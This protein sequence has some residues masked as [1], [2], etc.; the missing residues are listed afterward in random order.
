MTVVPSPGHPA[1][2][3]YYAARMLQAMFPA[4]L[5]VEIGRAPV[6]V[7]SFLPLPTLRHTRIVVPAGHPVAAA[8]AVRR[9]LTGRRLRT[10]ASRLLLTTALAS[11]FV[12]LLHRHPLVVRGDA[13]ADG[14]PRLLAGFLGQPALMSFAVGPAR[15]NRKPVLQLT[16]QHGRVLAFAKVGHDDL[17]RSLVRREADA[18][19]RLR[20]SPLRG[21]RAPRVLTVVEWNDLLVLVLEPLPI[22]A[23]SDEGARG[24]QRLVEAVREISGLSSWHGPWSASPLRRSLD[25]QLRECGE[26]ASVLRSELAALD[27]ADPELRLGS[28]H[29]DLNPGNV[30]LGADTV[31]VWD[32]ERFADQ[33]PVGFDLLHHDLHRQIT[34]Q[35]LSPRTAAEALIRNAPDTLLPLGAQRTEATSAARLYLISLAARYLVDQQDQAG[36]A[37]GRIEEWLVPALLATKALADHEKGR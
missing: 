10:R 4:P 7:T 9:Q 20:R 19:G 8:R 12:D 3:D 36:S 24:R 27:A 37:L 34:V 35:E 1:V 15:S 16:D 29:G 6:A 13:N 11:G 17:T 22:N 5:S 31:L 25:I 32:W 2:A 33:V 26:R 28:W 14:L 30:R 23:A 21:V 18:L